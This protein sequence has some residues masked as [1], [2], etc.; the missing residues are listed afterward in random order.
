MVGRFPGKNKTT[1]R[2][3]SSWTDRKKTIWTLKEEAIHEMVTEQAVVPSGLLT[4]TDIHH[5]YQCFLIPFSSLYDSKM[6][7]WWVPACIPLLSLFYIINLNQFVFSKSKLAILLENFM[8]W[9]NHFNLNVYNTS[10]CT[11]NCN[12]C[13]CCYGSKYM[14]LWYIVLLWGMLIQYASVNPVWVHEIH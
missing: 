11:L 6:R 7:K 13:Q 12:S 14:Y 1:C 2:Y 8:W 4:F 3:P 5:S 10:F 9:F